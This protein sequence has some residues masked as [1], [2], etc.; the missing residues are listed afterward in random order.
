ME[1]NEY[2]QD[3]DD[4]DAT[5]ADDEEEDA[6]TTTDNGN[7]RRTVILGTDTRVEKLGI[8]TSGRERYTVCIDIGTTTCACTGYLIDYQWVLT[9]GHCL[10]DTDNNA[11]IGSQSDYCIWP[12]RTRDYSTTNCI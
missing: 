10:Y 2:N 11:W 4:D 9:A 6:P 12:R 5:T 7:R 8:P 3:D 1:D